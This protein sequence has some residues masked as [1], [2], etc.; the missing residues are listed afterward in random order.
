MWCRWSLIAKQLP[1]RTD[2]DV[3]NHWNTKLRKKLSKLGID[4]LTHK[5]F[6]LVLSDYGNISGLQNTETQI[7]VSPNKNKNCTFMPKPEPPSIPT[8]FT[9][10]EA[11][12]RRPVVEQVQT[13]FSNEI[14][15]S[16]D[17][18][19]QFQLI[20]QEPIFQ[21]LFN[22]T[23][24]SCSSTASSNLIQ[25]SSPPAYSCQPSQA[26][27]PL[28]SSFNWG[29]FILSDPLTYP[30]FQQQQDI[31]FQRV[32]SP[33]EPPASLQTPSLSFTNGNGPNGHVG[34]LGTLDFGSTL[35]VQTKTRSEATSSVSSFVE[36]ILEQDSEMRAEFPD[37]L[38]ESF[39]Y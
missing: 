13:G 24:S 10:T 27:I 17:S 26:Q 39:D 33:S 11:P 34:G 1:G 6:S 19:S 23:T 8:G 29:E 18:P 16:W 31:H 38:D 22:E 14:I 12:I 36:A 37:I 28:S 32:L 30:S 9:N 20:S 35:G 7:N 5:P 4:P 15:A 25:L 21:P 3:K 2:N